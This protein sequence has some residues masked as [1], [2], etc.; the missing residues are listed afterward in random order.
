MKKKDQKK[1]VDYCPKQ[2]DHKQRTEKHRDKQSGSNSPVTG[3]HVFSKR[4]AK[5][6]IEQENA[7]LDTT[8]LNVILCQKGNA[9]RPIL[10]ID[11]CGSILVL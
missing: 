3:K 11:L 1:L 10:R 5:M 9:S 6:M 4:S 8:N 7:Q 2:G